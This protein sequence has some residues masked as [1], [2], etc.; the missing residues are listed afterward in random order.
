[1]Q[2]EAGKFYKTRDG[3]RV[4][5]IS[6]TFDNQFWPFRCDGYY[7]KRDGFSCPGKSTNHRDADD[8]VD[9]WVERKPK[10][11]DNVVILPGAIGSAR[12]YIGKTVEVIGVSVSDGGW[13]VLQCGDGWPVV[14]G[15]WEFAP[16]AVPEFKV[17]D[18]VVLTKDNGCAEWGR[19]G[20]FGT[21]VRASAFDLLVDFD[22]SG[23]WYSPP[24]R[25]A[26]APATNP[27]ATSVPGDIVE[28]VAGRYDAVPVGSLGRVTASVTSGRHVRMCDDG[29]SYVFALDEIAKTDTQPVYEYAAG[30]AQIAADGWNCMD[31]ADAYG[32]DLRDDIAAET[33]A[34]IIENEGADIRTAT[35]HAETAFAY[36]DAFI[37]ARAA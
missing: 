30:D 12:S 16:D 32:S 15:E 22:Q 9:E 21:I 25:L 2:I 36:A 4:G 10:V 33:L 13:T 14:R 23:E 28:V 27:D 24:S 1:M 37:A 6:N 8:L 18:R 35:K 20:E 5:P 7:F 17:G 3:R 19:S 29:L 11:E 31:V 26:R 34:L